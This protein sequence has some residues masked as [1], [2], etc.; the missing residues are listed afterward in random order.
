MDKIVN[1]GSS[2]SK[3]IVGNILDQDAV[4]KAIRDTSIVYNSAGVADIEE[5]NSN[6]FRYKAG[7]PQNKIIRYGDGIS[8][9]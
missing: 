2:G 8:K 4:E 7:C 5:A 9:I 1:V 6:L 3:M